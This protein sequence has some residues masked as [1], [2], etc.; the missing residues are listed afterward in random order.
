M[1]RRRLSDGPR[2]RWHVYP[3]AQRLVEAAVRRLAAHAG[4]AIAARG[5]FDIVLSGGSTPQ[6]L[7]ASAAGLD[8]SWKHWHVYFAD[9]RCL[10]VGH[11]E[12]NDTA[13]RH[14]WLDQVTIP[15]A[16]VHPIPAELGPEQA[17]AAYRR[18]L[19]G[20]GPFD[21]VL[22]GL[23]EDGHTASLFPGQE[24]AAQAGAPDVLAVHGA[25]KPPAERVSLGA[26]RLANAR[27]VELIVLGRGKR[28]AVRRLREGADLPIREVVPEAGMDVFVDDAAAAA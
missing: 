11:A 20:V 6:P 1:A 7:Y 23:G 22:L 25:P 14:V 27:A 21:L 2:L 9:E 26:A 12:R 24:T 10:P 28:D 17:A 4:S 3:D 19:R 18:T 16:Q 5:R 8:T 15:E 13:A